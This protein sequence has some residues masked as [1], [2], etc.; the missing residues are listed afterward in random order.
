MFRSANLSSRDRN[1]IPGLALQ[2]DV[3]RMKIGV[4][5]EKAKK[6][7][8]RITVGVAEPGS[9]SHHTEHGRLAVRSRVQDAASDQRQLGRAPRCG[10]VAPPG[11]SGKL[12]AVRPHLRVIFPP[13]RRGPCSA[14][15][16][17]AGRRVGPSPA[18]PPRPPGCSISLPNPTPSCVVPNTFPSGF[19]FPPPPR[20]LRVK[21]TSVAP[22]LGPLPPAC[23]QAPR[24]RLGGGDGFLRLS[25][26]IRRPVALQVGPGGPRSVPAESGPGLQRRRRMGNSQSI[27][28]CCPATC[29][30]RASAARSQY[31]PPNR[32]GPATE[33]QGAVIGGRVP[34]PPAA[35]A[36]SL[37]VFSS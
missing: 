35:P 3:T 9:P 26:K 8:N 15:G 17:R 34:P 28:L 10:C 18:A 33:G 32:G 37:S 4:W 25:L 36:P 29:R 11:V 12:L 7:V 5:L 27:N 24:V 14:V 31:R 21:E 2:V 6:E 1:G 22:R 16:G 20:R 19:L 23:P 13:P 30:P